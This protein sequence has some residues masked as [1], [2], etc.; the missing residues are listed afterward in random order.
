M[1]RLPSDEGAPRYRAPAL[2]K[3]LDILELLADRPEGLSQSDIA[4]SLERSVGEIF[5]MI[6]CLVDRGYIAIQRPGDRYVLTLKVFE[7]AHRHEPLQLLTSNALPRM[8][9]LAAR[10][11][12]SCHLTV[13]ENG[14]GVVVAQVDAPGAIGFSVRVGSTVDLLPTAS[15]RVLLAFQPEAER[16]RIL[17]LDA[18]SRAGRVLAGE[19]DEIL[20]EVRRRGHEDMESTRIRGVRDLSF[21]V[22]DQ[23][24]CVI[25][26]L[27]MPFI[28][29]LD[30]ED[31]SLQAARE[32]LEETA[33]SL[34]GALGAPARPPAHPPARAE[35]AGA[36]VL[37]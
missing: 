3:G 20:G 6:A 21:P 16:T 27:T 29:R 14:H 28:E 35:A 34:S 8:R 19:W 31:V 18:G 15:G 25:A 2:E 30:F 36:R 11:H 23:G 9:E 5:R 37:R 17:S 10:V 33:R 22:L 24:A 26:A 1:P 4:R 32:A 7:L 13:L 12:Q